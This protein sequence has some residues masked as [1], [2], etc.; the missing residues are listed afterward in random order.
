[1]NFSDA[2]IPPKIYFIF[3]AENAKYTPL[4]CVIGLAYI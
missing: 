3:L 4:I 1:L 2:P